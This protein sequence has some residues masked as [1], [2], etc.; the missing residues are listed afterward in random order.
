MWAFPLHLPGHLSH[1]HCILE[2]PS[3]LPAIEILPTHCSLRAPTTQRTYGFLLVCSVN[4][5]NDFPFLP[6]KECETL[7]LKGKQPGLGQLAWLFTQL[8]RWLGLHSSAGVSPFE[9]I[10]GAVWTELVP[11]HVQ[12]SG[13]I[14]NCE[15]TSKLYE[16]HKRTLCP[17]EKTL[18]VKAGDRD[19]KVSLK[20]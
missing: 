5:N 6:P 13:S 3:H 7:I 15:S 9:H 1:T 8:S 4:H 11:L 16:V 12:V 20:A 2:S 18:L 10:S 19:I 14:R 17:R